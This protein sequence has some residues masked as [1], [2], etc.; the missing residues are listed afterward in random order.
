MSSLL[1]NRKMVIAGGSGVLGVPL[2]HHLTIAGR[3]P[4]PPCQL[5]AQIEGCAKLVNDVAGHR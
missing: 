5:S 1:K 3:I 4:I 2:A